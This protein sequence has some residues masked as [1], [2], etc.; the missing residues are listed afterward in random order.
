MCIRD[1]AND[2]YVI[3]GIPEISAFKIQHEMEEYG[4][5][6]QILDLDGYMSTVQYDPLKHI[7]AEEDAKKIVD[8]II[9]NALDDCHL[10]SLELQLEKTLLTYFSPH[11]R[12]RINSSGRLL[13]AALFFLLTKNSAY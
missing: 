11:A 5:H 13:S 12:G 4:R 10:D 1:R 9:N 6:I 3:A 8:C 2:S 7:D